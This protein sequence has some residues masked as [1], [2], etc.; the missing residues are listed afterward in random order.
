[1]NNFNEQLLGLKLKTENNMD[2]WNQMNC[3]LLLLE[4]FVLSSGLVIAFGI[5]VI[6]RRV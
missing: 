3:G 5:E 2:K 6:V 1:M 4:A